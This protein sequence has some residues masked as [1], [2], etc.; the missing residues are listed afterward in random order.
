M[1]KKTEV[2]VFIE[3]LYCDEC[4]GEMCMDDMT[5]MLLTFPPQYSYR[6]VNCGKTT[7]MNKPYP[8]TIY[9]EVNGA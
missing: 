7:V 1:I 4:G 5:K 9:E 3:K 2:K 6:C 8:I